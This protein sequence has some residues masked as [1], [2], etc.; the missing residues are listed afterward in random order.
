MNSVRKSY[1]RHNDGSPGCNQEPSVFFSMRKRHISCLYVYHVFVYH[2]N[3]IIWK[4]RPLILFKVVSK[5]PTPPT[6]RYY[7]LSNQAIIV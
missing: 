1:L 7:F 6:P 3:T 2:I 5:A 4:Y